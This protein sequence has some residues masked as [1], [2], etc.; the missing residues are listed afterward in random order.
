MTKTETVYN[1]QRDMILQKNSEKCLELLLALSTSSE[2]F[3]H[4]QKY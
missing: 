1:Q 3:Y 2:M 4:Y